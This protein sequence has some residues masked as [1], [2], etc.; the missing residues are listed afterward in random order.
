[1]KQ[2]LSVFIITLFL[3][4]PLPAKEIKANYDIDYGSSQI[5]FAGTHAGNEFKGI[6]EKWSGNI[7]F[8]PDNLEASK[9]IVFFELGSAVTG[10]KMYDGTLPKADWFDVENHPEGVFESTSFAPDEDG[11]YK[12]EGNLSLRGITHP[13]S[14]NFGLSDVSNSPVTMKANFNIDRLQYE[15]GKKSDADAEWVSRDIALEL[16]VVA[17]P[18]N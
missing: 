17:T 9:A 11:T 4:F 2:F 1:M 18:A 16:T 5:G 8:D 3:G 14:F 6:F 15:I 12:A 7:Y 13:V 10:N